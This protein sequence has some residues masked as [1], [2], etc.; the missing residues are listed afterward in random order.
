VTNDLPR[1]DFLSVVSLAGAAIDGKVLARLAEA[2]FDDIRPGHGY[3]IQRLLTGPQLITAMAVD[4]GV[5]Q[6]A[7]SKMVKD[8]MRLG[9]AAQRIDDQ[10]GRRRPITLT[11]RGRAVVETARI[12]RDEIERDLRMTVGATDLETA[13]RVLDTLMDRFGL[14]TQ[15]IE[16]KVP[17][18]PEA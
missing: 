3:L 15:L 2:G 7:V 1:A 13:R 5:S 12:A 8:L 4:L 14:G 9:L 11:E 17:L 6:Q 16:R 10:D 18:P